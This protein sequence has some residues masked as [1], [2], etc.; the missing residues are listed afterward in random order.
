MTVPL[1][2]LP[3]VRT[4]QD[5][6]DVFRIMKEHRSLTNLFCDERGGLTLGHTDKVLGPTEEKGLGYD[7]FALFMELTAIEFVPRVNPEALERMKSVWELRER[8]LY[9][10]A[11]V[12]RISKKLVERAKPLVLQELARAGGKAS[13]AM[14]TGSHGAEIMRKVARLRWRGHRRKRGKRKASAGCAPTASQAPLPAPS[15]RPDPSPN[16]P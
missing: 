8:P 12:K 13:G 14:R 7:T 16:A 11:R 2:D 5:A 15:R 6:V 4:L 1:P 10:N 3:V 9:P